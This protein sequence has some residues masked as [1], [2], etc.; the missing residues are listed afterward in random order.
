MKMLIKEEA[1]GKD[2]VV[3]WVPSQT[4]ILATD[5]VLVHE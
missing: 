3:P 2:F 4:D 1:S 5:W